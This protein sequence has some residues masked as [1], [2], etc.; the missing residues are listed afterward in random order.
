M[1]W[2]LHRQLIQNVA[3]PMGR[4]SSLMP[5]KRDCLDMAAEI[6]MG[7]RFC[8]HKASGPVNVRCLQIQQ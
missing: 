3:E 8:L 7:A 5:C 4:N 6:V 2:A 1:F